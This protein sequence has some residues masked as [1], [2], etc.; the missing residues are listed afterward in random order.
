MGSFKEQQCQRESLPELSVLVEVLY[1]G[2]TYD[3]VNVPSLVSFEII[4]RW[5]QSIADA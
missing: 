5:I 2:G 4:A 3:Q 1:V